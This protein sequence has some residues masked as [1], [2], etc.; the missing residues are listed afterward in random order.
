MNKNTDAIQRGAK[1]AAQFLLPPHES[2][3][4]R[5]ISKNVAVNM[6]R[7]S[8]SYLVQAGQSDLAEEVLKLIHKI[9]CK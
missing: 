1:Q 4:D 3:F 6:I 9:E 7:E 5:D 2:Q 8:I